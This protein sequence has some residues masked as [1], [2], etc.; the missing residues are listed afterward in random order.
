MRVLFFLLFLVLSFTR[1]SLGQ[2]PEA[3]KIAFAEKFPGVKSVK[4]GIDRNGYWEGNFKL[5]GKRV[6]SDFTTKGKWVETEMSIKYEDLPAAVKA[7]I[8]KQFNKKNIR[9][10]EK[11]ANAEKGD[12][13]DVEFKQ[14]K[15]VTDIEFKEDGTI[16]DKNSHN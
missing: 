10:V 11:V 9:E 16:Q 12:F 7:V 4:W 15:T 14:G 8:E 3:V 6:R 1:C 2:T 5:E 13:Y